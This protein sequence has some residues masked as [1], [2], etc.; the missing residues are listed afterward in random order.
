VS[1]EIRVSHIHDYRSRSAS[2]FMKAL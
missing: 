2:W 1:T